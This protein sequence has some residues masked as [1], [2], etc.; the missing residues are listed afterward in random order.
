MRSH[1]GKGGPVEC[2]EGL[3]TI[4]EK[5]RR[6]KDKCEGFDDEILHVLH[7]FYRFTSMFVKRIA[8]HDAMQML[9]PPLHIHL[10]QPSGGP[11]ALDTQE[12][13][14][15]KSLVA[16]DSDAM[17]PYLCSVM[18]GHMWYY[19]TETEKMYKDNGY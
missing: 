18:K 2:K 1:I 17:P 16:A 15:T 9:L 14:Q 7:N 19:K 6:S 3:V 5:G 13:V 10:A 8:L 4:H 12:E 11:T